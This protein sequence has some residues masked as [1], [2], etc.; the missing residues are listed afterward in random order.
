MDPQPKLSCTQCRQRKKKCDKNVPC[1]ACTRAGLACNSVQRARLPRG[2]SGKAKYKNFQ[3]EDR[4]ARIEKLLKRAQPPVSKAII[5]NN[6]LC[7]GSYEKQ[8]APNSLQSGTNTKGKTND[9]VASEFWAS[10]SQE[11]AGL[12]ETFE[13]S[14]DEHIDNSPGHESN[15]GVDNRNS[16]LFPDRTHRVEELPLSSLSVSVKTALL[17]VYKTRIHSA[18]NIFHWPSLSLKLESAHATSQVLTLSEQA[19]ENSIY[20]MAACAIRDDECEQMGLGNRVHMIDYFRNNTEQYISK[21][22]LLQHPN[23]IVLQ[24]FMIYLLALRSCQRSATAWTL[25][26]VA[27]R[28]A[29]ALG[30]GSED[31]I[32]Y[33]AF[34]LEIRRRVWYAIGVMDCQLA[35]DRGTV[36][37][38]SFDV[39]RVSP[40][41]IND[42][43]LS[44]GLP[45]P[46]SSEI[47]TDMTMSVIALE[48]MVCYKSL[49]APLQNGEDKTH[50]W[51]RKLGKLTQMEQSWQDKFSFIDD[52][53][54]TPLQRLCK[55]GSEDIAVTLHLLLR[56]PLV[57]QERSYIPP[58][59]NFNVLVVATETLNRTLRLRNPGLNSWLWKAWVKW[60][61]LAIVLAE[62]CEARNHPIDDKIY[63]IAQQ[64]FEQQGP[65]IADTELGMLWRP[66]T[67]LMHRV[68][69]I[70]EATPGRPNFEIAHTMHTLSVPFPP[71]RQEAK[72]GS[73]GTRLNGVA[74]DLLPINYPTPSSISDASEIGTNPQAGIDFDLNMAD[75][76]IGDDGD[77]AWQNWNL[78]LSDISYSAEPFEGF[79]NAG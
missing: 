57:R 77:S 36:D 40:Q 53:N 75:F 29:N 62:L 64:S 27:T 35:L 24:A 78:F 76:P 33:S 20:F 42:T 55:L 44:P 10:L 50:A 74:P 34:D 32:R 14:D 21:A 43:E 69:Q 79:S 5:V 39:F 15:E 47:M 18:W 70:K 68:E 2:R 48:A 26:A 31:P 71:I 72:T 7:N 65:L 25:F 30:L 73:V 58:D 6:K 67:K 56:R 28:I 11:V 23:L 8:T 16:L 61:A 49:T 37:I 45:V 22:G 1:S 54:A 12:R 51:S 60:Y 59:D 41:N 17:G 19:L 9:F 63:S 4:V 3:L 66:I 13:N 46:K 52:A 38:L